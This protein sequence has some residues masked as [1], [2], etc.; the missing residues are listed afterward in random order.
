[1][2][3]TSLVDGDGHSMGALRNAGFEG[4]FGN[5]NMRQSGGCYPVQCKEDKM[6]DLRAL[7]VSTA[8]AMSTEQGDP[9]SYSTESQFSHPINDFINR[10]D[11]KLDS[12]LGPV[13]TV[14]EKALPH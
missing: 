3:P 9:H 11:Q 10:T 1:N 6:A 12:I 7:Y 8:K 2:I 13:Y 14:L 4:S 5:F